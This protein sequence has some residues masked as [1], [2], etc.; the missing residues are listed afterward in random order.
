MRY[1]A[2]LMLALIFGCSSEN[3]VIINNKTIQVEIADNNEE[4]ATGLMFREE[5]CEN[6]GMLFIF[7]DS[8]LRSFWMKD[9]LIPLDMIFIDESYKVVDIKHAVPCL[10]GQCTTYD[11]SMKAK[12][13]LELNDG[14][15]DKNNIKMGDKLEIV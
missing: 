2:L 15:S 7:D 11:S 1:L 4:R 8:E 9:T 10:E 12:Y 13:V 6:C 3:F 5:L 14:F